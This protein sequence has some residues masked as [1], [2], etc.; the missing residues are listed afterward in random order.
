MVQFILSW[1]DLLW[2]PATIFMTPRRYWVKALFLVVCCIITLR[3]Q[4]ELMGEI[5]FP[6]GMLP[7][8]TYPA[9]YRGY[10]VYGVFILFFL[11]LSAFSK[12]EHAYIYLAA[13]ISLYVVA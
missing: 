10:V 7:F 3:L 11:S 5:G 1:L 6:T 13:A 9:L 8:L 2:I 12:K 4:V